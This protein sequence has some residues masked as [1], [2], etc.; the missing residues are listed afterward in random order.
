MLCQKY[1]GFK[2]HEIRN[3]YINDQINHLQV[4]KFA[5]NLEMQKDDHL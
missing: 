2:M 5:L 4:L 3:T 1:E